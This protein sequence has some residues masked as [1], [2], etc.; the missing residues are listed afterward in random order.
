MYVHVKDRLMTGR[1]VI[2]A[3]SWSTELA[4]RGVTPAGELWTSPAN[5]EAPAAVREAGAAFIRAGAHAVLANT[6][7]TG[8]LLM[9]ALGR[10]E[11]MQRMDARAIGLL[12]EAIEET[13]EDV[14]LGGSFSVY[15]AI[16]DDER[17]GEDLSA[18]EL[19]RLFARKAAVFRDHGVDFI[20]MERVRGI[21][22]GVIATEAAV[23]TGL[24]VWVELAVQRGA[25]GGICSTGPCHW[26]LQDMVSALMSTG[27]AACVVSSEDP[28]VIADAL[29][30]L[31]MAWAG[32][33]GVSLV[34]GEAH[35]PGEEGGGRALWKGAEVS[36]EEYVIEADRWRRQKAQIFALTAGLGS[37]H[38]AALARS[39]GPA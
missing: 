4:A 38:V 9:H 27:A 13:G 30:I 11:D 7:S 3:G 22:R 37:A 29:Q 6:F 14:A 1:P 23:N 2:L 39:F 34:N 33:Q 5:L 19:E 16:P 36:P 25:E 28:L 12:R 32:Y 21:R 10:T 26:Q 31:R 35:V 8:P 20:Y 18:A 15:G 24:P 17:L